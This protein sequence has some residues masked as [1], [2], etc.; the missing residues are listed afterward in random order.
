MPRIPSGRDLV[1]LCFSGADMNVKEKSVELHGRHATVNH[2][3]A[4]WLV[5]NPGIKQ[6]PHINLIKNRS[7]STVTRLLFRRQ[8]KLCLIYRRN[9]KKHFPS[10]TRSER[11]SFLAYD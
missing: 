1:S 10:P 5:P 4:I 6:A 3:R 2:P 7:P 8:N 9:Q 11:P